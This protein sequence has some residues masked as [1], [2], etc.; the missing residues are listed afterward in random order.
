MHAYSSPIGNLYDFINII[1]Y[2]LNVLRQEVV[3]LPLEVKAHNHNL[4][5][6]MIED[7]WFLMQEHG[8]YLVDN[9]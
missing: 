6:D 5:N 2:E 8:M 7:M 1:E 4:Y 9:S 3:A